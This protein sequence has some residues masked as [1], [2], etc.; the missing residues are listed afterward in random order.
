MT[1]DFPPEEKAPMLDPSAIKRLEEWGGPPLVK[2]M[3]ALFLETSQDRIT[4]LRQG[5]ADKSLDEAE[6]AAHS[7]KSSA[8]NVGA[9]QLQ[10]VSATLEN[11]LSAKDVAGA[12][13]LVKE[14]ETAH[15]D[16]VRALQVLK[17]QLP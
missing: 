8:A 2:K 3:V 4:Q 14:L 12:R 9:T 7:L 10:Q 13:T 1:L 15:T 5:L 16:A 11:R 6:R 17:E